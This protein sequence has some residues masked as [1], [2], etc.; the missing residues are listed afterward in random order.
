MMFSIS[1]FNSL[2][3]VQKPSFKKQTINLKRKFQFLIGSLETNDYKIELQVYSQE[4]QFLIG[5]LETDYIMKNDLTNVEFQFLIGSL[6]TVLT[7]PFQINC[8]LRFNSLQVV[9]KL[10]FISFSVT[11]SPVFQ[12]LIGSLETLPPDTA[13]IGLTGFNSLQV[14]QKPHNLNIMSD[15]F[16]SFNS[17]QVVQKHC[18]FLFFFFQDFWFQFLIGSLETTVEHLEFVTSS[19]FNSLQVV[20]KPTVR[21]DKFINERWFQFL[22]GSLETLYYL[23]FIRLLY[24]VSIP[25]RQ[26]RNY[27]H[28]HKYTHAYKRFNSLQVVQKPKRYI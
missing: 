4:F 22:I 12:F 2:Q 13:N 8:Y 15:W 18:C 11:C 26:S 27:M 6:E 10:Y 5:S 20:Q 24:Y 23:V 28:H 14:V 19:C 25:Y 1:C 16:D 3:V 7:Q 21:A 9:Q 17:L